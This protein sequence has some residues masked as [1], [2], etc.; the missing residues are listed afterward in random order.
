MIHILVYVLKEKEHDLFKREND[1]LIYNAKIPLGKALIGCFVELPTLDGR[2]LSV[3]INDIG[4]FV[5]MMTH[6]NDSYLVNPTYTKIVYGEGMPKSDGS[7]NGNLRIEFDIIFPERLS[8]EK[9]LLIKDAL[10]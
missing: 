6:I 10:L 8:P 9:K 2:L 1:D 7:G 5:I 3:P 4:K